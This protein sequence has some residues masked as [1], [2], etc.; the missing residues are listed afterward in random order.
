M[1]NTKTFNKQTTKEKIC[2]QKSNKKCAY[3]KNNNCITFFIFGK[4]PCDIID[5][6]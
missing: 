6:K 4:K 5:T 3:L 2:H 1:I